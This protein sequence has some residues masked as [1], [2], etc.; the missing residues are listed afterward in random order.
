MS[1]FLTRK[2][3]WL[4]SHWALP[5]HSPQE[6]ARL[7]E[8]QLAA[9]QH[10]QYIETGAMG[11]SILLIS[12]L[13]EDIWPPMVPALWLLALVFNPVSMVWLPR[14]QRW[15][16]A[17]TSTRLILLHLQASST[18]A[19]FTLPVLW[20]FINPAAPDG[21]RVFL[22]LI[23]TGVVC[24][25]AF[26]YV[27]LPL[28]L[29]T[30]LLA[31]ASIGLCITMV[32][33]LPQ[34]IALIIIVATYVIVMFRSGLEV[35]LN[36][37]RRCAAEF[38]AER[39]T[40]T[41][42]LLLSDFETSS[43]DW[44]WECDEQL[45]LTHVSASMCAAL[46]RMPAELLGH[47]ILTVLQQAAL[48]TSAAT[49]LAA[50]ARKLTLGHPFKETTLPLEI[51]GQHH[52]W[53]LNAKPLPLVQGKPS[54]WRGVGLDVTAAHRHEQALQRLANLDT[55]TGL[56]NRHAFQRAIQQHLPPQGPPAP[57]ALMLMDLDGFK[58]VNDAHGH[59]V[60]D[61]LLQAVA[62]R[63][64]GQ[65]SPQQHLSR[66]GGDEFVLLLPG[67]WSAAEVTEQGEHLLDA[68]REPFQ[69]GPLCVDVR[70]SI[71]TARTPADTANATALLQAADMAL[72]QAKTCGRN[73]ICAYDTVIGQQAQAR[74]KLIQDLSNALANAEMT[75]VYQP[76]FDARTGQAVGAEALLRWTHPHQG[77]V[78]P[79]TFIPLAESTGL[80]LPIGTWVLQQACQAAAQWSN[81]C[82]VAVNI[83]ARQLDHPDRLL[84]DVRDA[85]TT[86]GLPAH[87]LE[88]EVTESGLLDR[89]QAAQTLTALRTLGVRL[90]L[91]DFGTGFSS[92]SYLQHLPFDGLKIDRSFI[93]PL[94][95]ST[96][97]T[98]NPIVLRAIIELARGLNLSC[99]AE[100][101]ESAAHLQAVRA[102][103]CDQL[104][105]YHL[106]LP[107]SGRQVQK[108][109]TEALQTVSG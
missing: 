22:A 7:S 16:Q 51:D 81:T 21:L 109:F 49:A 62:Q 108:L 44:F 66:L 42:S 83:S 24:I 37:V 67:R 88:L 18:A 90:V 73:R 106:G 15:R 5:D 64:S 82:F 33:D 6:Q 23:G 104:Q 74:A 4:R 38:D 99:T 10:P 27:R 71:G 12:M 80:I 1:P 47:S 43:R 75:L 89:R 25:G 85:L 55:L 101:I 8:I 20:L 77:T 54:G 56:T 94:V 11:L 58:A 105:G 3:I 57:L 65:V 32:M 19:V 39:Q 70:A 52:W 48:G 103:G 53:N 69:L 72:Y 45:R 107:L 50:L 96:G 87:R 91:D 61:A 98:S 79:D 36:L 31:Y 9:T 17:D 100:G 84:N 2:L 93:H 92:L 34:T 95:T 60:G 102:L 76:L 29:L 40:Q 78:T 13:S 30:W 68:L 46:K 86:H 97:V 14:S 63:L 26:G 41:V 59:G 28:I 35:S